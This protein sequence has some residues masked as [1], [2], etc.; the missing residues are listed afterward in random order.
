MNNSKK[1]HI[2][3]VYD[4]GHVEGDVDVDEEDESVWFASDARTS[5][6]V[7][8]GGITTAAAAVVVAVMVDVDVDGVD[9]GIGNRLIS[10]MVV[11]RSG[12]FDNPCPIIR[13]ATKPKAGNNWVNNP[14]RVGSSAV[15]IATDVGDNDNN[16]ANVTAKGIKHSR[17]YII[18]APNITSKGVV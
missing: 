13:R 10:R 16:D 2:K 9:D 11:G 14:S 18:Y 8:D 5:S 17:S 4:D 12:S 7:T 1:P 6:N 3:R 15:N